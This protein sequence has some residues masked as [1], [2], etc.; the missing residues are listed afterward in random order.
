MDVVSY[1]NDCIRYY[2]MREFER[3]IEKF[4]EALERHPKDRR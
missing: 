1:F 4:E 2:R 3:A